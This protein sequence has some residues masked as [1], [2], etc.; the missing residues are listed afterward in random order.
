MGQGGST[1]DGPM[2][3]I[4][5]GIG[6][7]APSHKGVALSIPR[8]RA[9][10]ASSPDRPAA[11]SS[12]VGVR[13]S[14]I[15]SLFLIAANGEN[16]RLVTALQHHTQ[17]LIA[18]IDQ[19]TQ[20]PGAGNAAS[21]AAATIAMPIFGLVA[22]VKS[23]GILAAFQARRLPRPRSSP[24]ADQRGGRSGHV[25]SGSHSREKRRS[26]G[27]LD[28][29]GRAAVLAPD[30]A[31]WLPFFKNSVS[32]RTRTPDGSPRCSIT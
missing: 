26:D 12:A 7:A 19:V 13:K 31:E 3:A 14:P 8:R 21:S 11:R 17:A 30:P 27:S 9:S 28:P 24:L 4:A 29:S 32:S 22:N 15:Q 2:A 1:A 23:S 6:E 5:N 16:I 20:H 10:A 18:A 25:P